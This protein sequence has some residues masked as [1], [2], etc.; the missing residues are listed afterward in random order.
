M[1]VKSKHFR[2]ARNR[3]PADQPWVWFTREMIE[4][5]AWKSLTLASRKIIERVILEHMAHGGT[6]NGLLAVT[7]EDFVRFGIRR[8]SLPAAIKL[9]TNTGLLIITEKGRAST[10]PDRWPNRFALGWLPM[11]D[12]AA[13]LNRWKSWRKPKSQS[14]YPEI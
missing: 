3:P 6:M 7:Y 8:G 4:S 2:E 5:E 12:G 9:A 13:A 11:F 14:V 10:G 1:T